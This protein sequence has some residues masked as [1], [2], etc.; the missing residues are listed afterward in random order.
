MFFCCEERTQ[1]GLLLMVRRIAQ[2]EGLSNTCI[3]SLVE[4]N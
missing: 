3:R 4:D 1:N 2:D